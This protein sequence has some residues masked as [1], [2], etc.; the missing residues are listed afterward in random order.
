M[1]TEKYNNNQIKSNQFEQTKQVWLSC[2]RWTSTAFAVFWRCSFIHPLNVKI[3]KIKQYFKCSSTHG[4]CKQ[5]DHVIPQPVALFTATRRQADVRSSQTC[6]FQTNIASSRILYWQRLLLRKCWEKSMINLVSLLV[7]SHFT[8]IPFILPS[9]Y[10]KLNDKLPR[11]RDQRGK[12]T[13]RFPISKIRFFCFCFFFTKK[14][15]T[16]QKPTIISYKNVEKMCQAQLWWEILPFKV[17][18]CLYLPLSKTV[19]KYI[20]SASDRISEQHNDFHTEQSRS[21]KWPQKT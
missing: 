17:T 19:G 21:W 1:I 9:N 18:V 12:K 3:N 5:L 13:I 10:I 8:D 20:I 15:T 7:T 2:L 6:N 14:P 4:A 16:K 11:E